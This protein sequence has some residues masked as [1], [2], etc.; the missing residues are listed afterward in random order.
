MAKGKLELQFSEGQSRCDEDGRRY[1]VKDTVRRL[2]QDVDNPLFVKEVVGHFVKKY[3]Q[4][5]A[6]TEFVCP[7]C[8]QTRW[9]E[10]LDAN[11]MQDDG[12]GN[13]ILND[14]D[15]FF[16]R[17]EDEEGGGR[18]YNKPGQT[19]QVKKAPPEGE[20][21]PLTPYAVT[22]V[23]GD[24]KGKTGKVEGTV[25]KGYWKGFRVTLSTGKVIDVQETSFE[26]S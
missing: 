1:V 16:G 17:R 8:V 4:S 25:T 23:K 6:L 13:F 11:S 24:Y 3:G 9:E 18:V 2:A 15:E 14:N 7:N 19:Q 12:K 5:L 10:V 26:R 20:V 21:T 22:M